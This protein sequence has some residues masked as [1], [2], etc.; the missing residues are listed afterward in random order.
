MTATDAYPRV[1]H[2]RSQE[3]VLTRIQNTILRLGLGVGDRLP[4]ETE[5]VAELG[6]SRASVRDALRVLES[7]GI[8]DA[9]PGHGN[10]SV[11][12]GRPTDAL[13][14][15]LRLRMT[16]SG[17]R[18]AD[19]CEV[20]IQLERSAA[21]RAATEATAADRDHL[22][23]LLLAMRRPGVDRAEFQELDREFHI[24]I[25][26]ASA[27]PLTEDL[28][29]S[30]GDAVRTEMACAFATV[31]DWAA[32]VRRLTDEHQEILTA[33][34]EGAGERAAGLVGRHIAAFYSAA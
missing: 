23:G 11:V 29:A 2:I 26:R 18:L 4:S 32:T 9:N 10:R 15:L 17:F 21:A 24:A 30:L 20:R 28:M 31:T 7:M 3:Q 33:L 25:A 1:R 19:L 22:A 34:A 5:L 16:L 6:V 12:A 27:N 14:N 8:L 13:A